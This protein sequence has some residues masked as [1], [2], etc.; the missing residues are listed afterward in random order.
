M[1]DVR[2]TLTKYAPQILTGLGIAGLV[3]AGVLA[4]KVTPKVKDALTYEEEK[5]KHPLD[6]RDKIRVAWKFYVPPVLMA[7]GSTVALISSCRIQTRRTAVI[8]SAYEG[9]RTTYDLYKRKVRETL[10]EQD[11][12]KVEAAVA[13][14][15]VEKDPVQN[16]EVL[17]T[18]RGDTLCYDPA[19]GR[20]FKSSMDD[21]NR[22]VAALNRRLRDELTITLNE[23]YY[24]LG[25][26]DISLGDNNGWDIDKTYIDVTY[27]T[28]LATD[29]T[30][31]L[32]LQYDTYPL[33]GHYWN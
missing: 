30:P 17:L 14:E 23:F 12:K 28:T 24:E 3:G 4:V 32:A 31:C 7:A 25:L 13:K 20:Y 6:W 21:I 22:V 19:S 11:V 5:E 18:N 1:K 15:R 26:A 9:L 8:G 16:K 29:G 27:S 33:P 10:E 2:G